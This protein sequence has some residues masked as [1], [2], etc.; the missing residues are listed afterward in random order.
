M[1]TR[2][3]HRRRR[4]DRGP[5]VRPRARLAVLDRALPLDP[6]R[7][8]GI[9]PDFNDARSPNLG[10]QRLVDVYSS[11]AVLLSII[12]ASLMAMPAVIAGY[13]EAGILR[14][15]R[16]TPVHPGSLLLAQVGLHAPPCWS[17]SCWCSASARVAYDVRLPQRRVVR[18]VR[19][20]GDR[21]G[22]LDRRGDH[23]RSSTSPVVQTVG[24]IVLLPDDVH[25]RRL[26]PVQAM[27]GWLHAVVVSTPLGA[28]AEA[29]NDA[30]VGRT[31]DLVDLAV[32]ARVDA[33]CC[34][35]SPSAASGGN[36]TDAAP[37]SAGWS[38]WAGER[39][40]T[41]AAVRAAGAGQPRRRSSRR[42]GR[43]RSP[44][45]RRPLDA[46]RRGRSPRCGCW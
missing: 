39:W 8:P 45:G 5:A 41:V 19:G 4:P 42:R 2:Q 20:A 16:T 31:P 13:R 1:S 12:M 30:L 7:D 29:L 11:V 38:P 9:V 14:R 27:T 15:L 33:S 23:G 17:R 40:L 37:A 26:F 18:R 43:R 10:G 44:R 28:A 3:P 35:W 36:D 22:V 32:M 25:R 34:R 46:R 6:G 24:T 21:R